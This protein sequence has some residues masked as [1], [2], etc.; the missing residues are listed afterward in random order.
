MPT[1][2]DYSWY[3]TMD[4]PEGKTP[5]SFD[6]EPYRSHF[7]SFDLSK[8]TVLDVGA[9]DGFFSFEME[10]LGALVT[11]A[12]I[13]SQEQRDNNTLGS[14]NLRRAQGH[15]HHFPDAYAYAHAQLKSG[16][17]HILI[18]AYEL[19]HHPE[20]YDVVFC[21]DVLLHLSDPFRALHCFRAVCKEKLVVMTPLARFDGVLEDL[22]KDVA[23]SQFLGS[24]GNN[25]FWLPSRRCFE[26]MVIGAG[27]SIESSNVFKPSKSHCKYDGP[28]GVIV[29]SIKGPSTSML[30]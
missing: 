17:R 13:P 2:N 22:L 24:R 10:K 16:A 8:K 26:E 18:N 27:F 3:H 25:A 7:F 23:V 21:S 4:L 14:G 28:R 12:D 15:P 20:S 11:S 30:E 6:W 1:M 9:G 5:G 29:A 19:S